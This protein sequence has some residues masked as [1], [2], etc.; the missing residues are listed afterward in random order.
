MRKMKKRMF[1]K[2][3]GNFVFV[4]LDFDQTVEITSLSDRWDM[5]VEY[6]RWGVERREGG[7][8]VRT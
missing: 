2:C 1:E 6:D 3:M 5:S 4:P 8:G 7:V